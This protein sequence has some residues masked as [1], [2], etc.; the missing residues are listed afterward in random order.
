MLLKVWLTDPRTESRSSLLD[1]FIDWLLLITFDWL[2]LIDW[3]L[4]YQELDCSCPRDPNTGDSVVLWQMHIL[5]FP[6]WWSFPDLFLIFSWFS[7]VMTILSS[8]TDQFY[9]SYDD[10]DDDKGR[11]IIIIITSRWPLNKLLSRWGCLPNHRHSDPG[12]QHL[13]N[14]ERQ[15][16]YVL[17][18]QGGLEVLS[19][20]LI[21]FECIAVLPPSVMVFSA[22]TKL[23][24]YS[25]LAH[26]YV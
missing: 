13:L 17:A 25:H 26:V 5:I 8:E 10:D 1:I 11:H 2:L 15:S 24:K 7:L 22:P 20:Q 9:V 6:W 14:H 4:L 12:H 3:L 23:Q 19:N 21:A 18:P 16:F